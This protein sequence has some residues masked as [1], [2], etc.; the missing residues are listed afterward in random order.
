MTLSAAYRQQ[1]WG[2]VV[3]GKTGWW[4]LQLRGCGQRQSQEG[5]WK[6]LIGQNISEAFLQSITWGQGKQIS[7]K[8]WAGVYLKAAS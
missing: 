1:G 2:P 5:C 8:G 3:A 7:S 4:P 6:P